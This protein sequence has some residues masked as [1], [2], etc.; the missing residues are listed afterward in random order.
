MSFN[1]IRKT[2][3]TQIQKDAP[4]YSHSS[5][6]QTENRLQVEINQFLKNYHSPEDIK[7]LNLKLTAARL[8]AEEIRRL[9]K[10]GFPSLEIDHG[11]SESQEQA[12]KAKRSQGS[13]ASAESAARLSENVPRGAAE[14]PRDARPDPAKTPL[15]AQPKQNFHDV[16]NEVYQAEGSYNM[17]ANREN[18]ATAERSLEKALQDVRQYLKEHP[19][20]TEE[21]IRKL[22]ENHLL[23]QLSVLALHDAVKQ[24]EA[25]T[26]KP[27][28][29]LSRQEALQLLSGDQS[30]LGKALSSSME[31][32][33]YP[34]SGNGK[35][36][37]G[38]G[39]ADGNRDANG[40]E[41]NGHAR[42]G[43]EPIISRRH[44]DELMEHFDRQE[45]PPNQPPKL[46]KDEP[47]IWDFWK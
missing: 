9:E 5:D 33:F 24:K 34:K 26:G 13:P 35:G 41:R 23:P 6:H 25:V 15:E 27:V 11:L 47:S 10:L 29:G 4:I 28:G 46:D 38:S 44:L 18:P 32:S 1:S 14:P 40:R 22:D 31:N 45:L 8:P 7:D 12:S 17:R 37:A 19:E 21:M 42:A 30:A 2:E 43:E 36:F 3:L 20:D 39:Y 16:M